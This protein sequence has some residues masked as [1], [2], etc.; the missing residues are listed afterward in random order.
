MKQHM[1]NSAG[2][3]EKKNGHL[4]LLFSRGSWFWVLA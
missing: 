3:A 4:W 2:V 1:R